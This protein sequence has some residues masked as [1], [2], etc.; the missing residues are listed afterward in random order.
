RE[1]VAREG[2]DNKAECKGRTQG[3]EAAKA[4]QRKLTPPQKVKPGKS[5][6]ERAEEGEEE[7]EEISDSTPSEAPRMETSLSAMGRGKEG[8]VDVDPTLPRD[9]RTTAEDTFRQPSSRRPSRRAMIVKR[10]AGRTRADSEPDLRQYVIDH[11]VEHTPRKCNILYRIL[12]PGT[13]VVLTG[14]FRKTASLLGIRAVREEGSSAGFDSTAPFGDRPADRHAVGKQAFDDAPA[15][16]HSPIVSAIDT[17]KSVE[18]IRLASA[19]LSK[20]RRVN[21][22]VSSPAPHRFFSFRTS[23]IAA[24]SIAL[25]DLDALLE[26]HRKR[27]D[28]HRR[29]LIPLQFAD[30]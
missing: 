14:T 22:L 13:L 4:A 8:S 12:H 18:Q 3:A 21:R 29:R 25:L 16:P 7:G 11:I 27:P 6:S 20:R 26:M 15:T 24:A 17:L 30:R 23:S 5:S 28:N 10:T 19:V 2:A 9:I 1:G